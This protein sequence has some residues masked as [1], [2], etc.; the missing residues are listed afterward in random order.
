MPETAKTGPDDCLAQELRRPIAAAEVG[1]AADA[2]AACLACG[3]STATV[4]HQEQLSQAH[5]RSTAGGPGLRYLGWSLPLQG[6][7]MG[8]LPG[9]RPQTAP[10]GPAP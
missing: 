8:N 3:I 9:A 10:A 6:V 5:F 1:L 4:G 7:V 2:A